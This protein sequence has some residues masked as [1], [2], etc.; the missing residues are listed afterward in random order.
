[1][2]R[3]FKPIWKVIKPF[4]REDLRHLLKICNKKDI[5]EFFARDQLPMY[6]GGDSRNRLIKYPENVKSAHELSHLG[7]DNKQIEKM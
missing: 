5:V 6:L 7:L 3:L 1:M 2:P 4:I